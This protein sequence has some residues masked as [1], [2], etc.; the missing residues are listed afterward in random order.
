M[1]FQELTEHK[2]EFSKAVVLELF[3]TP[4]DNQQ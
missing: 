1:M 3:V 2:I 4:Q